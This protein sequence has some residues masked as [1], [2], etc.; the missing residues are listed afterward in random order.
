MLLRYLTESTDYNKVLTPY[1][2]QIKT[3]KSLHL[4]HLEMAFS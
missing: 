4:E 1:L 2:R 3:I